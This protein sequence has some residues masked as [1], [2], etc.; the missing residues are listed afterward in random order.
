MQHCN[1]TERGKGNSPLFFDGAGGETN[2][3]GET[4]EEDV[5][6][7]RTLTLGSVSLVV[8]ADMSTPARAL[9]LLDSSKS[10]FVVPPKDTRLP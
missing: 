10:R 7:G 6:D 1:A 4:E 3:A 5:G 9:K 2:G 8:M